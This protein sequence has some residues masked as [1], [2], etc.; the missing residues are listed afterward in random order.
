MDATARTILITGASSGI[1]RETALLLAARGDRLILTARGAEGLA[2]IAAECRGA[3]AADV[4]A[5]PTD[6][7]ERD[8]VVELFDAAVA[9]FGGIDVVI[10]NAAI[11]VF[12]RFADVPAD[13]FDTVIKTNVVGAA[14]VARCAVQH[15]RDR[16]QGHLL[17]VGSLLGHTAV[18]YMGAYVISKFAVTAMIRTLRQETRELKGVVVHGIYPGAVDTPIYPLSANYFGRRARVQPIKDQPSKQARAIVAAIDKRRSSERQVGLANRP[19]LAGYRVLPRVFDA[20]AGPLQRV[21]TFT[22]D[23][24]PPTTGNAIKPVP[25]PQSTQ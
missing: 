7:S 25:S 18:P 22:K 20:M 12:G 14:N 11:A 16:G 9:Q 21:G 1:G 17:I 4:L 8:Q 23:P 13:I 24:L 2:Q 6:I 15:F 19:I 3:G 5:R 10:Q